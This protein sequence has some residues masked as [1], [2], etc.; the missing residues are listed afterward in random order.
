[1][2]T[3]TN[4]A[5]DIITAHGPT[6]KW[7]ESRGYSPIL[8]AESAADLKGA[9]LKARLAELNLSTSGTADEQRARIA[10]QL[11]ELGQQDDDV[12]DPTDPDQD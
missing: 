4:A 7:A 1:M 12:Q 2:G 6:A 5:G 10:A 11:S 3:H 9:A 8:T